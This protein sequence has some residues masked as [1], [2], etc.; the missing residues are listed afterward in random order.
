MADVGLAVRSTREAES[1]NRL[2]KSLALFFVIA[3]VGCLHAEGQNCGPWLN[4]TS[5]QVSYTISGS[6]SGSDG[7][8]YNW[9]ISHQGTG[10]ATLAPQQ[11]GCVAQ[12]EWAAL[13]SGGSGS[14]N[15]MGTGTCMSG[16]GSN[17][18]SFVGSGNL[19]S[20]ISGT[21]LTID[22]TNNTYTFLFYDGI[23]VTTTTD[24][25]GNTTQGNGNLNIGPFQNNC[26]DASGLT[27][28]LPSSVQAL[29]QTNYGFTADANCPPWPVSIGWTLS[30]TLTPTVTSS[31]PNQD[32]GCKQT[33]GAGSPVNS[34]VI[35][36]SQSL[37]EDVPIVGTR[38]LLHYESDREPGA[39]GANGVATA[40]AAMIGGWTLSVHHAY[41]PSINTLFLGD[42]SQRGAWQLGTPAMYNGNYLLTSKDGSEVYSFDTTGRHL[43]TQTPLTGAVKYKFAYDGSGN[44]MSITDVAG[45]VTTILRNGSE[46]ATAIVSPYSQSTNLA[47]D[48]KGF[49]SAITDPRGNL[50]SFANTATGLMQSRTD[51]NG[52]LFSFAYDSQGHLT[53]DSDPVGG[54]LT[55][56]RV[57]SGSGYTVTTTTALGKTATYQVTTP[58]VPGEAFTNT[59]PNG[60]Q[61][62]TTNVQQNGQLSESSALPDGTSDTKTIGP[63]PRW[64]LQSPVF[65]NR[66]L[67]L[68]GLA[69]TMSGSRTASWS[70]SPF[71]LNSQTDERT[72]NGRTYTTVFTDGDLT[73]VATTPVKRTTTTVFDSLERV[74]SKQIGSLLPIKLAYDSRGRISTATQGTRFTTFSY[75]ST[76]FLS[77]VTDPLKLSTSFTHDG[78]G[79]LL[80][81]TLP[82]GRIV[83]YG[84][85]ANANLTSITPAGKSAHN[86]TYTVFDSPLVYTPPTVT[87]TGST[88]FA[89]DADRNLKTV[90]R[91]D[92]ETISY[93]YDS[94]GRLVSTT[95]PTGTIG[96]T[97]D[98]ITGNMNGASISG[99]EGL[100]YLFNGSLITSS[101]WTGTVAG[102]VSRVYN[103]NF[104]VASQNINSSNAINFTYDNDG[105]MTK[106]GSL[107]VKHNAKD[108]L[109]TG[110]TLGSATDTRTYNTYG[111]LTGLTAKYKTA[112]LYTVKFTL[113]A[114][115][116]ITGKTE[117]IGSQKNVFTYSYDA[118][119]R[120]IGVKEN[121]TSS[122]SYTYDTNSNRLT[123]TTTAGTVNGTY[124]AQ[125]RLLT[126]GS[127][128]FTYTA[129]GEMVSQVTGSQTTSYKYDVLGNLI[130]ATLPSGTKITYVVDAENHRVGKE[131]NGVLQTGFLYDG[132]H[133]V[134]Q[135]NGSNAIVSQFIYATG[136]TSP[137]YMVTGGVTYRIYPDNL[138]S[139]RLVVNTST[140]AITEQIGYDEFGNVLS[141]TSPGFQPFGFAGGLYDQDTRLVRLGARDYNPA[142]GRWTAKDPILF[143]GGDTN[144]YGYVL[145]D[146]IDWIDPSGKGGLLD[147]F[148]STLI[149]LGIDVGAAKS[150][151][152]PI[153]PPTVIEPIPQPG[154]LPG[155]G[156]A[157]Q[158]ALDPNNA[159]DI[160]QGIRA[161]FFGGG[162]NLQRANAA[163]NSK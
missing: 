141:D 74:S 87:G 19:V 59:W 162:V 57:S 91:P 10:T 17:T 160:C 148:V 123:A 55:L 140:G 156:P 65:L 132:N 157:E 158:I 46:Q 12:L 163:A 139:P 39:T 122:S 108:G 80:S 51:A 145:A 144:L 40:D 161:L 31:N 112:A 67:T 77:G 99:G 86:F 20:D 95:T 75:D 70:G 94:A 23:P 137:D 64:G 9:T 29:T 102:N 4:V 121:G 138:G 15:D 126:Y 50:L 155:L 98:S 53:S 143:A 89:Y 34:S 37:G 82:D 5:W 22:V 42:G 117:T 113:D 28:S 85:D 47:V 58:P 24:N 68:G 109:I 100:A 125:D 136:A 56:S 79:N 36:Q 97:Y 105:L 153:D 14:I 88:S 114:D 26:P 152:Q 43:Q 54:S 66:T 73:S 92:G 124:D 93:D 72:V 150:Q 63:D 48:G 116:R 41:D 130:G 71:A 151:G 69:M 96:Y 83:S 52:N 44:L 25:C 149:N 134:A 110:T 127:S 16:D 32:D 76:G 111:E 142:I 146:P 90:T 2:A 119:G 45:N 7:K 133:I 11:T 120:L 35:C 18:L 8:E 33:E 154:V 81:T 21:F 107:V 84:Y 159:M 147:W 101:T 135:L 118:T 103:D 30:F 3:V 106:A 27:F 60:L 6:G 13:A 1:V 128:S 61:A 38:F 115:G 131:V 49:L 62:T 104:W 129:N 78:D